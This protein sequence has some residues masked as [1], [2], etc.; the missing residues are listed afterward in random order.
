MSYIISLVI[1]AA[2]AF[3]ALFLLNLTGALGHLGQTGSGFLGMGLGV[4]AL[5]AAGPVSLWFDD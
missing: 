2:I 1:C 4:I 5:L 3:G